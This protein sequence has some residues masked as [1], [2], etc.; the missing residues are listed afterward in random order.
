MIGSRVMTIFFY[1]GLEIG[2]TPSWV[3]PNIWRVR[4]VRDTQFSTNISNKTL[5]NDAKC[6]F[7]CFYCFLIIKGKPTGEGGL[8]LP[9]RLNA[10]KL[11]IKYNKNK[12]TK[13]LGYLYKAK[14]NLKKISMLVLYYYFIHTYINYGNIAWGRTN[15]TNLKKINSQQK[16]VIRIIHCKDRFTHA[17]ELFWESKIL[18]IFQLHILNNL[19]FT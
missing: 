19:V 18:N 11:Q 17:R 3:L 13:N 10:T 14:H 7:Y 6:Q 5:L 8:L 9:P 4:R 1:K 12:I 2:N 15:K 16:H